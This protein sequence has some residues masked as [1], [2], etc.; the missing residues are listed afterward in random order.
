MLYNNKEA[1]PLIKEPVPT[2]GIFNPTV[3]MRIILSFNKSRIDTH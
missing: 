3:M 1:T 2:G